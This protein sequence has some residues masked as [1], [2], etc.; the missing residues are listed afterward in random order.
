MFAETQGNP[1]KIQKK[2]NLKNKTKKTQRQQ[3][4]RE[5]PRS[6]ESWASVGVAMFSICSDFEIFEFSA[7]LNESPQT[8]ARGGLHGLSGEARAHHKTIP[9]DVPCGGV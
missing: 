7:K 8:S 2:R 4:R 6:A 5:E 3:R 1:L 9:L